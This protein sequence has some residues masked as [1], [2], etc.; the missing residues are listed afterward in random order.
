MAGARP[1]AVHGR[2]DRS[3]RYDLGPGLDRADWLE[4]FSAHP[5]IGS[6]GRV[7]LVGRV[8]D[9][10]GRQPSRQARRRR[11][12][13]CSPGWSRPIVDAGSLWLH[14]H[15]LCDR[16]ERRGDAAVARRAPGQR[17]A[18]RDPHCGRRAARRSRACGLPSCSSRAAASPRT[19]S[20]RRAAV[21]ARACA[22]CSK[23]ATATSWSRVGQGTTDANG[24]LATLTTN[25]PM[26]A[27]DYR[28]TV[29]HGRLPA[30]AW[31]GRSVFSGRDDHLHCRGRERSTF[32]CRCC[33]ARSGARPTE[34]PD[35]ALSWN[36][37]GKS[38]VRLVKVRRTRD[39]HEIV[40]LT[41]A[42]QLE[43]AFETGL[44]RGRQQPVHRHRYDEE[45][46][47]RAGA[48]GRDR[49]RRSL[50]L[51]T[52]GSFRGQARGVPRCVSAR[53]SI[54]GSGCRLAA[55]APARVRAAGRRAVDGSRNKDVTKDATKQAGGTEVVAG[56]ESLV[57][58]KTT[59][60]AFAGFPRDEFT[61]LPETHDRILATS[62]TAS[63]DIPARHHGLRRRATESAARWSRP[64]PR[65]RASR[66]ST[67]STRWPTPRSTACGDATAITL[68]MP[69]RHHLLVNLGAVRPRQPERRFS[70]PTEQPYGLIEEPSPG[71]RTRTEAMDLVNHALA[72][73]RFRNPFLLSSAPPTESEQNIV[74]A[75]EAGWG[76]VVT[77][78]IGLHP[79]V[80]VA[81]A[82]RPSSCA[83]TPTRRT[84]R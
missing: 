6:V 65:T 79:V 83:P 68:T 58:L 19:C 42:V 36:R 77:K 43:G 12:A 46:R 55:A 66:C 14:L 53:S 11:R 75:F 54:A 25:Q 33:S 45:H 74:R 23:S 9:A 35:V 70:S 29:R 27:G 31:R 82:R 21:P 10:A 39:P 2:R 50:R 34:D 60:S 24:R 71:H 38:Q 17:S 57:V 22:S 8:G 30:R 67:R 18:H 72:G 37:Y 4:A 59:D 13:T 16:Q 80:N 44:R 52:G 76:G 63:V 64:S 69:N 7:G 49:A 1:F 78:T 56:L 61:T 41:I 26:I 47:L 28:L 62:V 15:R 40:D 81:R 5:Q 32:T 51:P 20:T 3:S 73:I 84:C 48:A